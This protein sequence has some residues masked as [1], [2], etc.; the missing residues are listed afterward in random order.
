[1]YCFFSSVPHFLW[2]LWC[3]FAW[4][5]TRLNNHCYDGIETVFSK[6]YML[7]KQISI[8]HLR[9]LFSNYV[10]LMESNFYTVVD[11]K[12]FFVGLPKRL[13][14]SWFLPLCWLVS[15]K[16]SNYLTT[17]EAW[18]HYRWKVYSQ[19]IVVFW[20]IVYSQK[21]IWGLRTG[22]GSEE[23]KWRNTVP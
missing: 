21:S 23:G 7:C 14:E 16:K 1:M 5:A 19:V 6:L 17:C 18:R 11:Y 20:N 8:K 9:F 4:C 15:I 22:R 13:L 10:T 2:M 12:F 3:P